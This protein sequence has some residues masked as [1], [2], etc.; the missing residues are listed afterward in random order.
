MSVRKPDAVRREYVN[1]SLIIGIAAGAAAAVAIGAIASRGDFRLGGAYAEVVDVKP[2]TK[3]VETPRQVCH[4]AQVTREKPVKDEHQVAGTAIGAVVGGILGHQIG[5]GNGQKLATV[6]GAAAGGYAGNRVQDK[7]QKA[8][9]ET[10]TESQC[11]TV[12]DKTV[13]AAGYRVTYKLNGKTAVVHMS[14]DPGSKIALKDGKPDLGEEPP[15]AKSG[16]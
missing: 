6:A 7:M 10:T 4:D 9:T 2:V 12:Y 5:G 15:K 3:T 14:H 8:D 16:S 11:E 13:E 1:K